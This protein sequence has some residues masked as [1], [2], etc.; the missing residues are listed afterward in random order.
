MLR[1]PLQEGIL[2]DDLHLLARLLIHELVAV[3]LFLLLGRVEQDL[4]AV[5]VLKSPA[6]DLQVL[7]HD[8]SLDGTQL[9]SLEGV[10]DAEAD[11]AGI[12]ADLIEV[13]ADELLLLDK[14]D[15]A[16][17]LGRQ[18]N[19]LVEAVLAT[20]RHV[21]HLDDLGLEAVV[22]QVGL[23]EIVLEVGRTSKDDARDV[24]LVVGDEVLHRELGHLADV[25]VALLLTET[26]ETE[27]GLTTTAVLLGEIDR[28]LVDDVTRVAAEGAEE[29]AVT[30]HD[31][32][33]ELLVGL[34]QL[35]EGLG[36]ELVVTE[37]QRRV[38]GLERLEVDVD[39]SLLAL[40]GQDF[41][42]V[43][44][45]AVG[46]DLVIELE[47]LLGRRNGR[48]DRLPV[49]AGLD[50]RRG[51][52]WWRRW[53]DRRAGAEAGLC[54]SRTYVFFSQHLGCTR[55]LVLG[56]YLRVSMSQLG[57]MRVLGGVATGVEVTYG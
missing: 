10:L 33:A 24:G 44:D 51:A 4:T 40:G 43:D 1:N 28:E 50:V 3:V 5:A 22:E 13:L 16:E 25:V 54:N 56:R 30:V 29:G 39:L 46:R 27:R 6:G 15:V 45:E 2:R 31:D 9:E 42:A 49:D 11:A 19:G 14:L 8:Q 34:E 41:T 37:V 36:V 38:D 57:G 47:A 18:L 7:E 53:L 32:E 17:R 23:V 12:Q 26:G 20:V 52:L 35:G 55:H 21:H 48:Q